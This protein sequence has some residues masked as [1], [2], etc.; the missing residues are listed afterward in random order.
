LENYKFVRL[1]VRVYQ[2]FAVL[3]VVGGLASLAMAD[4]A[5]KVVANGLG[6]WTVTPGIGF[7]GVMTIL[8]ATVVSFVIFMGLAQVMQLLLNLSA[9]MDQGS[10]RFGEIALALGELRAD[11]KNTREQVRMVGSLV[12]EEAKKEDE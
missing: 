8:V 2:V 7:T 5:D 1:L 11:T 9:T 10:I 6:S 3:S 12:Y 4:I